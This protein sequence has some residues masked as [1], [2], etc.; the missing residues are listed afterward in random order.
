MRVK[1]LTKNP[2]LMLH[3]SCFIIHTGR[4]V[5]QKSPTGTISVWQHDNT[6]ANPN[7][8]CLIPDPTNIGAVAETKAANQNLLCFILVSCLMLRASLYTTLFQKKELLAFHALFS[9]LALLPTRTLPAT[10]A[11][12]S[13]LDSMLPHTDP[14]SYA[15]LLPPYGLLIASL[16]SWYCLFIDFSPMLPRLPSMLQRPT[17]GQS[18][19]LVTPKMTVSYP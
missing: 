16:L 17:P 2:I 3:A 1:P 6:A 10:L 4:R 15:L 18:L 9:V 12:P 7:L 14:C 8:P 19:G 13:M 11:Y 5:S